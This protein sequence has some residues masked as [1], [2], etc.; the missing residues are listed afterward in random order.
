R[1]VARDVLGRHA[2]A[3]ADRA[4][5]GHAP[6]PGVHGRADFGPRRVGASA[7]ARPA[8][9]AHSRAWTGRGGG[10]PRPCGGTAARESHAGQEIRSGRGGGSHRPGARRSA[11]SVYAAAGF[12]GAPTVIEIRDLSKTFTLHNQGGAELPVLENISLSV[13]AGECVALNGP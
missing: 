13:K 8:A 4:Q 11:A 1:R 3:P 9:L 10:D 2:S 6:A 5:P 12:F 7:A